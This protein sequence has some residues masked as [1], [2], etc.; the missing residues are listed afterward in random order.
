[1]K[2]SACDTEIPDR[3]A[4]LLGLSRAVPL[5]ASHL[6]KIWF[7]GRQRPFGGGPRRQA[8]QRQKALCLALSHLNEQ[9]YG[10]I[11]LYFKVIKPRD[12]INAREGW[13]QFEVD[14]CARELT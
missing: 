12:E 7:G 4:T 9:A 8:T 3:K 13:I 11:R 2:S 6:M 5:F 1:M 14:V 10:I